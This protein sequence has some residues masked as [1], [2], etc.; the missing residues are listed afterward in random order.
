MLHIFWTAL[1]GTVAAFWIFEAIDVGR[2]APT[3]PSVKNFG[4]LQDSACPRLS[5]LFAARDEAEKM[6]EAIATLLALDYPHY[7]IVAVDDRSEDA[8]GA[9]L[10]AAATKDA[11]LKTVHVDSLPSGWLGKPHA[12]QQAFEH[13]SGEW[14]VFTDADVHFAPDLLRRAIALA[15]AKN[16]EHLTLLCS[17]PMATAGEKIAMLFFGLAFLMGNRPWDT[18]NPQS[19]AYM[20]V[21]AFQLIRRSAYMK[22]GTH[23][24]LAMEVLD[25][26]KLGK[27]VKEA[28]LRSGVGRGGDAVTVEWHSGVRNIVRGTTKNFFAATGFKLWMVTA[29]IL[30]VM[31]MF[32]F[33]VAALAFAR[34]WALVFAL[35]AAMVPLLIEV[36]VTVEVKVSPLYA[37]TYPIG[38]LIMSWMLLRSTVVTLWQGGVTWRGTFYPIDELRRGVV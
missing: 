34:G 16:W 22:I 27:L 33:P 12:L 20:G 35:I 36:G 24:R 26:M 19:R 3:I 38:A 30:G 37:L 5:I 31:L 1:L 29:Q 6:P 14:L 18:N 15:E 2:G 7:E 13:S 23:R 28:G 4:P 9:I 11:R 8:T 10:A 32:V 21:G 25:D 17:V